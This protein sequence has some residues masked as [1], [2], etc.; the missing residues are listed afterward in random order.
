[1]RPTILAAAAVIAAANVAAAQ[2]GAQSVDAT[3]DR[4]VAAWAKVRTVRGTF[5]QTVTNSITGT[6][7]MSRGDYVQERPNRLSIRFTPPASGEIVADG[8]IVW[9]YLP[10]QHAGPGIQAPRNRPQRRSD[11]PDRTVPRRAAD[12][13]R[14]HAGRHEDGRSP[15]GARARFSRPRPAPTRRSP[16]RRSGSTMMIR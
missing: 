10:S 4:A 12:E 8:Q 15:R 13:V 9:V 2:T 5:E 6:S 14:H 16:R 11:R 7:A 3:I 1:M